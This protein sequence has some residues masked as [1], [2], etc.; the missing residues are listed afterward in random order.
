M[1][2]KEVCINEGKKGKRRKGKRRSKEKAGNGLKDCQWPSRIFRNPS[3]P[4]KKRFRGR[5]EIPG[6]ET[7]A[8]PRAF[9]NPKLKQFLKGEKI[10]DFNR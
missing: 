5:Q 2:K 7:E 3:G 10:H 6:A 9:Q 1:R 4:L 8:V